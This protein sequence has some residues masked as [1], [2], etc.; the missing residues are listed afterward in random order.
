[1]IDALKGHTRRVIPENQL[2]ILAKNCSKTKS[3][4]WSLREPAVA[5]N[6]LIVLKK[7]PLHTC[8]HVYVPC[9]RV[10]GHLHPFYE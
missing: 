8:A 4:G 3:L 9:G 1:M 10:N 2:R 6:K 5:A 7:H